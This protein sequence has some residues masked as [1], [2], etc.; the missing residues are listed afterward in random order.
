MNDEFIYLNEYDE[1]MPEN[2]MEDP[3]Q[4]VPSYPAINHA[5]AMLGSDLRINYDCTMKL[6]DIMAQ[7]DVCYNEIKRLYLAKKHEKN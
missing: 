7:E 2:W 3:C 4:H 5:L 6:K 1:E